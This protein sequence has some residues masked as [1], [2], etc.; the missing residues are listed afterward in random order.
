MINFS[1]KNPLIVNLFLLL[2]ILIGFA[3]WTSM[4][5]EMFPVVE[6]DRIKILTTY[7]GATPEEVEQQVTVPIESSLD[8]LQDVDFYYSSSSEGISKVTLKMLAKSAKKVASHAPMAPSANV[9]IK[10]TS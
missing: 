7:E 9:A 1:I 2:I 6:K 3:S 4:P 5:A 8:N 10:V